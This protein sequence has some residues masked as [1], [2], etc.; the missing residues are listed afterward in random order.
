MG[1]VRDKLLASFRRRGALRTLGMIL[2][3]LFG[4]CNPLRLLAEK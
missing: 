4:Y 3:L 2:R 1:S